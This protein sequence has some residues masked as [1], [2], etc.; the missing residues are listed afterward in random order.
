[1]TSRSIAVTVLIGAV[2]VGCNMTG[3]GGPGGAGTA[4]PSRTP[5]AGEFQNPVLARDFPDP[6]I[7]EVDGVYYAY[8][9]GSRS[10]Y[11]IQAASSTDLVNWDFIGE[12]LPEVPA[13]Q[14]Q[15]TTE[16]TWAPT[17]IQLGDTFV[18]YYATRDPDLPRPATGEQANYSTCISKAVADNPAG[19][20][21]DDS[22]EGWICQ[23]DLGGSLDPAPFRDEDGT[24]YL[25]WKNDGNCTGCVLPTN[26]YLQEL[27]EDGLDLLGEPTELGV[28]SDQG[29]ER[30]VI[31]N[32]LIHVHEGTYYLFFSGGDYK[33]DS[34]AVGYATADNIHGPYTDAE[35][36]PILSTPSGVG[37]E[38][39]GPGGQW[40]ITDDDGELWMA[41]HAWAPGFTQ[42]RMWLD[43][44]VFEDGAAVVQGPDVGA[45]TAP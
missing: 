29:W 21:V 34:Y 24:L 12:V 32:P 11:H 39:F 13:W 27:S 19:P 25:V 9:T 4:N 6:S 37:N 5:G 1:M 23:N 31:E 18:M 30:G 38:P 15:R 42:R 44:V 28:D 22:E 41:Y 40:L 7:L 20:F 3:S 17:V 26:F 36:N 45:Q 14:P 16:V 2:L 35:E 33:N 10:G 8:A 43:E